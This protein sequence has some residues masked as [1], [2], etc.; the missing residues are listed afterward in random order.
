VKTLGVVLHS[1]KLQGQLLRELAERGII[2]IKVGG[3]SLFLGGR[4]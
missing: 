2:P 4:D 1:R 3:G